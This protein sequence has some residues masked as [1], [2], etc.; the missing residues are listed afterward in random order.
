MYFRFKAV[1]YRATA[2]DGKTDQPN[3]VL[4]ALVDVVRPTGG[5]GVPGLYMPG[6]PSAEDPQ[7]A[8]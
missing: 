8:R 5:I 2:V 1:G 7:A 4:E 6:D 3:A